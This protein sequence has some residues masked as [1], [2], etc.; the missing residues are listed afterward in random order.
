M[1]HKMLTL[2]QYRHKAWVCGRTVAG[3]TGSN[4]AEGHKCLLL[5]LCCQVE[6]SATSRSL[7][8]RSPYRVWCVCER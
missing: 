4:P 7:V 2:V 5:V 8:Q 6:V 1:D 3:T